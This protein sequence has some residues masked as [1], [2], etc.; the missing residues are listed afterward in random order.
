MRIVTRDQFLDMPAGT[1]FAKYSPCNCS[2]LFCK[3]L[4]LGKLDFEFSEMS[5]PVD[6]DDTGEFVDTL[7]RAASEGSSVELNF[8]TYFRDST[9]DQNQLFAVY[10]RDDL[11]KL[12]NKLYHCILTAYRQDKQPDMYIQW[13]PL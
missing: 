3:G 5:M 9:F 2:A 4:S 7:C 11:L 6:S 8:D 12:L 13:G 1:L 10:E